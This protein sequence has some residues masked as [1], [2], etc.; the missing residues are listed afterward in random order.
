[1]YG[2][3]PSKTEWYLRD[4]SLDLTSLFYRPARIVDDD[5]L[6]IRELYDGESLISTSDMSDRAIGISSFEVILD[7]HHSSAY[8]KHESFW[9]EASFLQGFDERERSLRVHIEDEY[10]S[11]NRVESFFI[12]RIDRDISREELGMIL[13]L[14]GDMTRF[15]KCE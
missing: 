1:M 6:T 2:D 13:C 8:L 14:Y 15:E 7:E 11:S 12:I 10:I 5:L 4:L 9:C 3:S